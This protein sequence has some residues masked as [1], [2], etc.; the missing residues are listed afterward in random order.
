[1]ICD[2]ARNLFVADLDGKSIAKFAPDGTKSTLATGLEPGCLA[3][4]P[5]DNL[6]VSDYG[7]NSILKFTLTPHFLFTLKFD[8]AGNWKIVKAHQ[9]SD[10]EAEAEGE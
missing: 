2:R 8:A 9:M 1:V 6:Y 7:S 4:D 5:S 3:L 10:K